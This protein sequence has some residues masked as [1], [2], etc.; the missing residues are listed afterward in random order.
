MS[1]RAGCRTAFPGFS[2]LPHSGFPLAFPLLPGGGGG[3]HQGGPKGLRICLSRA[4]ETA[5]T[6]VQGLQSF[7][8]FWESGARASRVRTSDPTRA[9]KGYLPS[10]V[11]VEFF[12]PGKTGEFWTSSGGVP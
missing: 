7:G 8:G 2:D 4:L 1:A 10:L 6:E 9:G 3:H 12:L 5:P 11:Q